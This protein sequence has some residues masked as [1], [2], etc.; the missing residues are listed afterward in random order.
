M[1]LSVDSVSPGAPVAHPPLMDP[2]EALNEIALYFNMLGYTEEQWDRKYYSL[3]MKIFQGIR[4]VVKET[5][6]LTY[7]DSTSLRSDTKRRPF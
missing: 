4:K 2:T 5:G 7:P 6:S 3:F 1:G